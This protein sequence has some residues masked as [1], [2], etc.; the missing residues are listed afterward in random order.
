MSR[1]ALLVEHAEQQTEDSANAMSVLEQQIAGVESQSGQMQEYRQDY[2]QRAATP[3]S[4]STIQQLNITRKFGDQVQLTVNEL[5]QQL[6]A[7]RERYKELRKVWSEHYRREQALRALQ[8]MD[9]Q[10]KAAQE[11]RVRR[12]EEDDFSLQVRRRRDAG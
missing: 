9:E 5:D 1:W 7:L 6:L 3:G 8:K 11:E 2:A 4:V 12:R 10:K